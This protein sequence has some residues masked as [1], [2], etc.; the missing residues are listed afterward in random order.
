MASPSQP[1]KFS[2]TSTT[3]ALALLLPPHISSE[4]DTL[5][6]LHD[7]TA[8]TWPPHIN[9]L[10][11]LLPLS[12]LPSAI[13]LLQTA[14]S[15]LPYHTLKVTLDDVG[16]FKH[17]KNATVYLRP[18]EGGE[19][20]RGLKELR[21]SL[22][23][24]LGLR[25]GEGTREGVWRP[26]LGVGQAAIGGSAVE[27]LVEQTRKVVGLEWESKGL[28]VLK[29]ELDGRM[30]VCEELRFGDC[31]AVDEFE[32]DREEERT[33]EDTR[34]TPCFA[35]SDHNKSDDETWSRVLP[36][37]QALKAKQEVPS[38]ISI[39][40]YNIMAEPTA[41]PFNTRLP[42]IITSLSSPAQP[43][44]SSLQILCLQEVNDESLPFILASPYIRKTYRYATHTPSSLMPSARNLVTL[45][46]HP[47]TSTVVQFAERH[48]SALVAK[49]D[50]LS[51][52]GTKKLSVA[53]VHL[54]SGLTDKAVKSKIQQMEVLSDFLISRS[55]KGVE[56]EEAR[57]SEVA[58]AGDFNL[59]TSNQTIKTA[60]SRGLITKETAEAVK[61]VVN[62][63]VW[64]DAFL[65]SE[66][67]PGDGLGD[68]DEGET[69]CDGGMFGHDGNEIFE[70]E[71]GATFDRSTNPIAAQLNPPIDRSPQRYDRVLYLKG[72]SISAERDGFEIFGL[73]DNEGRVG[74]DHYGVR[75]LLRINDAK[76]NRGHGTFEKESKMGLSGKLGNFG[77]RITVIEDDTD[78]STLLAPFLPTANDIAQ[79]EMAIELLQSTLSRGTGLEN[80]ILAPLGSYLMGTYFSDSDV[81]VLAIGCVSPAKFFDFAGR[82]LGKLDAIGGSFKGVHFVNSLV[83]IVEVCVLGIKFDLQYCQ[84]EELVKEYHSTM[85]SPKLQDLVFDIDLISTL[86][87]SSIRPLNTYRDSA[88]LLNTIPYLPSYRLAHQYVSLYLKNRGLYSAKFGYLGGIHLQ[89]MLNRVVKLIYLSTNPPSANN[90][91]ESGDI[92]VPPISAATI[93]RTFFTYYASFK[94]ST[95]TV[96]DPL[97]EEKQQ[98]KVPSRSARDAIFIPAI[99]MPTARPNVASS[100]TKLSGHALSCQFKLAAEYLAAGDWTW[101]LQ[102]A[103][104][105]LLDFLKGSGAFMRLGIDVWGI[106]EGSRNGNGK[107]G[108]AEKKVREMIGALESRFP[109]LFV[110]LGRMTGLEGR[111]WPSRLFVPDLTSENEGKGRGK[112][113]GK[114]VEPDAE[115]G[116][117][118]GYYL[119]GVSAREGMDK[120]GKRLM[121]G[122]LMTTARE[123]ERGVLEAREFMEGRNN[124]WVSVDVVRSK[125]V[126]GMGLKIDRRDWG[127]PRQ[128]VA[129]PNQHT[130]SPEEPDLEML[131]S[132]PRSSV[133]IHNTSSSTNLS[134][135]KPSKQSKHKLTPLRPAHEIIARIKWDPD[136][137]IDNYLIGYED[138]FVGVKEM[139]L[140][141]WK[142]ESTDEEFIPLH[143]VVW[144]RLKHGAG[145]TGEIGEGGEIGDRE[146]GYEAEDVDERTRGAIV[147]DRRRKIDCIFG[148]GVRAG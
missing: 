142:I 25:E 105:G 7:R 27:R 137:D 3:T 78:I 73:A 58:I 100:C 128:L 82:E 120:D 136:L 147:W 5:R 114:E 83:S 112:G 131:P 109:R 90:Q 115:E 104:D 23:G 33:S 32:G 94:W 129:V 77:S 17:R 76:S 18:R 21:G 122:K 50:F 57:E 101:C 143:R 91:N 125:E 133:A 80:L 6:N 35:F 56:L 66:P 53:N 28:V 141:R 144:I 30:T 55:K 95:S 79:R 108:I 11:P 67:N 97:L 12:S 96:I 47:F 110:S 68:E 74:S 62:L 29:R 39:S 63:N 44:L 117:F 113:K 19:C 42:L 132:V 138:R 89:L 102:T 124:V 75:A 37:S 87:P 13:P 20:E 54:T 4:L 99:H 145:D 31:E 46:S 135:S 52:K 119:I 49:F 24:V 86:S 140:G 51:G 26:H 70:G 36:A 69:E 111:V 14:L 72:G 92:T 81:D 123:F 45:A 148:S 134:T 10:Y 98:S 59:T 40:T 103:D 60:L 15:S 16:V 88:Y 121:E 106:S 8:H 126:L 84:A 146:E 65:A 118:K 93:I 22:E 2:L 64:E 107:G 48:K 1:Q 9:L 34:W 61:N 71:Q 43:P 85:P 41:P 116:Q 130:S 139:E 38:T 127:V